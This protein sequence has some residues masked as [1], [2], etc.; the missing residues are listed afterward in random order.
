MTE[1][2]TT[3]PEDLRLWDV[4]VSPSARARAMRLLGQR[5][6]RATE[7][8]RGPEFRMMIRECLAEAEGG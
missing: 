7:E 8:I 5:V 1:K 3:M 4:R 6:E 2:K